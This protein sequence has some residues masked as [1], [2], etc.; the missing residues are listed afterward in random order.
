[1]PK[2]GAVYRT[3]FGEYR[4]VKKLGE[5]GCG[6]VYLVEDGSGQQHALKL[7]DRTKTTPERLK[8]FKNELFFCL[9][10]QHPNILRV[11]DHGLYTPHDGKW[12]PFYVMPYYA[13]TLRTLM[14]EGIAPSDALPL[15]ET[16][17]AGIDAAHL[18]DIWHRDLKP[19]NVLYDEPNRA[20][21]IGDFGVAHF[22][23]E[24]LKTTLE[25]SPRSRLASFQYSAPE[26]RAQGSLVDHRA[27]LF[28]FGLI[29]NEMFTGQVIQ[30]TGFKTIGAVAPD[31][32]Y[33]DELVDRL[34]RNAP[35]DRPQSVKEIREH[36]AA[37]GKQLGSKQ[38]L[39]RLRNTVI[40]SDLP[41]DPLIVDPPQLGPNRDW[42]DDHLLVELTCKVTADWIR[43]FRSIKYRYASY[44]LATPDRIQ[45][46]NA[47]TAVIPSSENAVVKVFADFRRFVDVANEDY[48]N[49][50]RRRVQEERRQRRKQLQREAEAEAQRKRVLDQLSDL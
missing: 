45:F 35:D 23:E 10:N 19:E 39:D 15:I 25:T 14:K 40:E 42:K 36:M 27:D 11:T 46:Q 49:F 33:L 5:G 7:L 17:L 43:V 41:D 30:G 8:R 9:N 50:V 20:L 18:R 4:Q 22:S 37:L 24:H 31:Y 13:K 34:V 32:A 44:Q 47:Q 3:A 2:K 16:F 12:A 1:M 26:Q 48:V 28:A 21:V 38:R 29:V 6:T